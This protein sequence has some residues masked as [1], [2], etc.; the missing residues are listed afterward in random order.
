MA[1]QPTW[2][3]IRSDERSAIDLAIDDLMI[4]LTTFVSVRRHT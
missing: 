1:M 3:D 2:L 4:T